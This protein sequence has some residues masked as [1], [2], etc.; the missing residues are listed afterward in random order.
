[1]SPIREAF[2]AGHKAGERQTP[3]NFSLVVLRLFKGIEPEKPK[4][5]VHSAKMSHLGGWLESRHHMPNALGGY[6]VFWNIENRWPRSGSAGLAAYL[7]YS[8]PNRRAK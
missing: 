7:A 2:A 6:R 1:M 5:L 4:N 8:S 3:P